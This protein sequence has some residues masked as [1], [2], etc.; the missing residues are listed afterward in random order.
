[1]SFG[2]MNSFIQ[3]KIEDEVEDEDGYSTIEE[4]TVASV[5]AYREYRS[6]TKRWA[7]EP[8]SGGYKSFAFAVFRGLP[9]QPHDIGL[10]GSGLSCSIEDVPAAVCI[11]VLEKK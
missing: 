3:L 10:E 11:L 4:V 2:K 8:C 6:G 5:R 1:M 9:S 7:N